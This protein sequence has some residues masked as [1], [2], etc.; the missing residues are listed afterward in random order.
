MKK[1]DNWE[2][3]TAPELALALATLRRWAE[4]HPALADHFFVS[5]EINPLQTRITN[6]EAAEAAGALPEYVAY[7]ETM[8]AYN[9]SRSTYHQW[10]TLRGYNARR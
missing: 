10:A 9:F 5:Y 1:P 2:T 8:R 7:L 6:L 4:E 3:M